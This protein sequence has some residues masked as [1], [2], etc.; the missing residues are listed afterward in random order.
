MKKKY[1]NRKQY[2]NVLWLQEVASYPRD[3]NTDLF[4]RI[5]SLFIPQLTLSEPKS[6]SQAVS[7]F[8][9]SFQN[10]WIWRIG[11]DC[12]LTYEQITNKFTKRK[13][14]KT[15]I[16]HILDHLGFIRIWASKTGWL[17]VYCIQLLLLKETKLDSV[18]GP[19][20]PKVSTSCIL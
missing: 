18:I 13:E 10:I 16:I 17:L 14:K 5:P 9:F 6:Q 20:N 8:C 3:I 7:W 15:F 4:L 19:L 2:P 1:Y 12:S 11:Q